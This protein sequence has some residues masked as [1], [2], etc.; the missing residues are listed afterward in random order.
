[1]SLL[2]GSSD[3]MGFHGLAFRPISFVWC[4]RS[5]RDGSCQP[6]RPTSL[7]FKDDCSRSPSTK[8]RSAASV[9]R[10][11]LSSGS[12][13]LA[14]EENDPRKLRALRRGS[15][16]RRFTGH[17]D[18]EDS[19]WRTSSWSRSRHH[20]G[21]IQLFGIGNTLLHMCFNNPVCLPSTFRGIHLYTKI[22]SAAQRQTRKAKRNQI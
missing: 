11:K 2:S 16:F 1:M 10:H 15:I 17:R 22:K 8:R 13:N 21:S 4:E 3:F 19:T 6:P 9:P 14:D 7:V 20:H 5:Q 12:P 18:E